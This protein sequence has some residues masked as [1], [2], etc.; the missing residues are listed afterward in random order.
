MGKNTLNVTK[1]KNL[2]VIALGNIHSVGV[3]LVI[4]IKNSLGLKELGTSRI[5]I[6]RDVQDIL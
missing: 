2:N 5:P 6:I 4:R 1:N 3:S